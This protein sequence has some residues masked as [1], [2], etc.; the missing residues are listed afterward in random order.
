M[1]RHLT[2]YVCIVICLVVSGD[3]FAQKVSSKMVKEIEKELK[4]S[5][6]VLRGSVHQNPMTYYNY[7]GNSYYFAH[8]KQYRNMFRL[9]K[10]ELVE[11]RS[12]K[13][14]DDRIEVEIRSSRLGKGKIRFSSPLHSPVLNREAFEVGFDLC[15]K[16]EENA[17]SP[18]VLIGNTQSNMYHVASSNHLP[19]TENQHQFSTIQEAEETGMRPCQLCFKSTPMVSDYATERVLGLYSVQEIQSMN[20]LATDDDLQNRAREIGRR[21]L[22][23]WPIP[24]QGYDYRFS[25]MEDDE[26][27]AYAVPTGFIFVNR[28]L[29]EST[30][31][32]LEIESIIAHEIAHVERRH[33]YRIYQNHKKKEALAKGLSILAAAVGAA[34]G[35]S[36][37]EVL[38]IGG[39]T[40]AFVRV[41]T[42]V[43][44]EGYPR[45]MEEE[46]DAMAALYMQQ[47]YGQRGIDAFSLVLKKLRYYTDYFAGEDGKNLT[48]F[49][50]HP[51]LDDRIAAV[52]KSRVTVFEEP[53]RV[54]GRNKDGVEVVTIEM[55]SQRSTTPSV[56][57]RYSLDASQI[58]GKVYATAD[59]GKPREFKDIT[60]ETFEGN[61]IKLD[62]KEDSLVGPYEDQGVLLRGDLLGDLDT[63]DFKNVKVNLPGSKLKWYLE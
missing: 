54:V 55:H 40:Y 2:R 9:P 36:D 24:L 34:S 20:Q 25:V 14:K 7:E 52:T 61:K 41:A 27:N 29:L 45:S 4:G 30:E 21:V 62:N 49:R 3:I 42:N 5:Q 23:N 59:I 28:G 38:T 46:A 50:S 63:L 47:Q 39:L 11:L 56:A 19:H 33:S 15:F 13:A 8:S 35:K 51:L 16:S 58:L 18:A 1:Y 17:S 26:I 53:V 12:V 6:V 31:S 60:F 57:E 48:A 22:D 43:F 10:D 32:D 37:D 44:Y